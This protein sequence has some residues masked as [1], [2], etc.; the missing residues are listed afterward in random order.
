MNGGT[1]ANKDFSVTASKIS[2][3]SVVR[4][5]RIDRHQ[6]LVRLSA[7]QPGQIMLVEHAAEHVVSVQPPAVPEDQRARAARGP[8]LAGLQAELR[9]RH[10]GLS[11]QLRAL[12]DEL[13]LPIAGPS[14]ADQHAAVLG[15]FDVEERQLLVAGTRLRAELH[16]VGGVAGQIV[17]AQG[18]PPSRVMAASAQSA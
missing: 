5:T 10:A 15:A 6:R 18:F 16:D 4:E 9:Q 12:A 2:A 17:E 14:Q 7:G 11:V 3:F 1:S 8:A 13:G